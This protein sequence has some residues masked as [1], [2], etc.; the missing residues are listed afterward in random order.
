EDEREISSDSKE[1]SDDGPEITGDPTE[2]A[3]LVIGKK[4]KIKEKEP[5]NQYSLLDDLPFESEHKFRAS[6]VETEEGREIFAIGAPERILE[7]ST[8]FLSAKGPEK[9]SDEKKKEFQ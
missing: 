5:Y 1:E 2:A 3:M 7:L 6:L 4:A 8:E 9:M